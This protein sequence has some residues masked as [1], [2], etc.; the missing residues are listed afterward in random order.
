MTT[1]PSVVE[2]V[3]LLRQAANQQLQRSQQIE[4][5]QFLTPA[6][7]AQLMASM[8]PCDQQAVRILDA[9]AGVGSLFSALVEQLCLAENRPHSIHVTAYEIDRSFLPLLMQ[10]LDYCALICAQHEITWSYQIIAEDFIVHTVAQLQNPLFGGEVFRFSHAILNP[11]YR[12][13]TTDSQHRQLLRK[14]GI[15]TSNLYTAFL[16]LA[17]RLLH[18][19]GHLVAITPRSF[20]NG[21]YFRVFRAYL[22]QMMSLRRLH[23]FDSRDRTFQDG[24]VLQENIILAA[25]KSERKPQ[26]VQISASHDQY[27]HH[28]RVATVAYEQVVHPNDQ[29]LFIRLITIEEDTHVANTMTQLRAGLPDLGLMVSTGRVV[30]FRAAPFLRAQPSDDTVPLIYPTHLSMGMV[31]WPK[32][33][34]KP[35]AI[36]HT[37]ETKDLLIPNAYYV[38]IK[39]FS[40]KEEKRRITAVV[41][42]PTDYPFAMIGIE[43]HLNYI[44]AHGQGL[45]KEL[46]L[47]LA[48]FL[49][50]SLVDTY[51]RQFS[52]HTQ[53]NATDLRNMRYPTHE[54]LVALGEYTNGNMVDQAEIDAAIAQI[55]KI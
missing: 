15:E 48:L 2:Q 51:V 1:F 6:P 4:L 20:C 17:I 31:E 34:K 40:A 50:S 27:D 36:Q 14:V 53:I 29:Q 43:N 13:I 28:P 41:Y 45:R 23:V 11:P 7:I 9:G 39:R 16:A 24:D 25:T 52:G 42:D 33:T 38:L 10:T 30:D 5:G 19:N 21:T 47:G 54:Q 37:P 46:A 26:Q 49:N 44:H 3:E 55:L 8:F 22:L 32:S 35:N 18:E 12:K